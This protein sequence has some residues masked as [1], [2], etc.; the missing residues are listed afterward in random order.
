MNHI[1]VHGKEATCQICGGKFRYQPSNQKGLFCSRNCYESSEMARLQHKHNGELTRIKTQKLND[2]TLLVLWS[3]FKLGT[4]SMRGIFSKYGY[5]RVPPK[6]LL[7]LIPQEEY[8]MY[9]DKNKRRSAAYLYK[10]GA[11]YERRAKHELDEA[12]YITIRS[13]AS[14][15]AFDI[16]AVGNGEL[17]L[18]QCKAT[19]SGAN[20]SA[21]IEELRRVDVPAFCKKEL[22]VWHDR[23]GWVKTVIPGGVGNI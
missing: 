2:A 22:W 12:G 8:R 11:H 3:R 21:L 20:H 15:G 9:K 23:S 16:W 13:S 19:K 10:R 5:R 6:R 17:R 7:K 4:G 1:R 18:I 14:H